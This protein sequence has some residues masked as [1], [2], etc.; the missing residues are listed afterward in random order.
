[1]ERLAEQLRDVVIAS[2]A[3]RRV[4]ATALGV[5]ISEAAALED[6]FRRGLLAPSV[7]ARHL[8]LASAT[9]T[10]LIDRLETAGLVTRHRHPTDRRGVL[11]GL[12]GPGQAAMGAMFA[13]FTEDVDAAVQFAKPQDVAAFTAVLTRI[14]SALRERATHPEAIATALRQ[15]QTEGPG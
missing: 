2:D 4:M 1:M 12:T 15:A 5:G 3:C 13:L 8:G 11:V 7:L 10:A 6:F 9:V 14:A